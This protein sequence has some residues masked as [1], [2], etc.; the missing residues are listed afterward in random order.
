MSNA[1]SIRLRRA[2]AGDRES[3]GWLVAHFDP[4]VIAQVR[5]RLGAAAPAGEEIRDVVDEIWLVTLGR[6]GELRPRENRLTP[7]L[8]KFLVTTSFNV[9]NN[10][11]RR[12]I[13]QKSRGE[14]GRIAPLRGGRTPTPTIARIAARQAG[15]PTEASWREISARIAAALDTLEPDKVEVL[16]LRLIEDRSN[17]EI[18]GLLGIPRNTVAVRYRRALEALRA[19]LPTSIFSD[20][21]ALRRS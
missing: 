18:A 12:T 20:V 19:A 16:V 8:L 5:I 7:V 3:L 10:F 4:L 11:L 21:L 6:L 15:V 14:P 17:V 1:T 2:V 9:C 13:A